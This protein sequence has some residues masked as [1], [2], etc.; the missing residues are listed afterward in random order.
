L[1][2]GGWSLIVL[3]YHP[4]DVFALQGDGDHG[5]E[6]DDFD[7][8][9]DGD[10]CSCTFDLFKKRFRKTNP[11]FLKKGRKESFLSPKGFLVVS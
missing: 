3:C 11:T 10:N 1:A 5:E 6:D 4:P 7:F 2:L 9:D 8:D